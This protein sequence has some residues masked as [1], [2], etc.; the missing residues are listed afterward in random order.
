VADARYHPSAVLVG[1]ERNN[2]SNTTANRSKN[3]AKE[4]ALLFGSLE[5]TPIGGNIYNLSGTA[6]TNAHIAHYVISWEL[7]NAVN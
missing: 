3:N 7:L 5:T 2:Y 1:D 6:S 4:I